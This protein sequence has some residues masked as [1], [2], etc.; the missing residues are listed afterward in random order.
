MTIQLLLQADTYYLVTGT[1]IT[2]EGALLNAL[3]RAE[4]LFNLQDYTVK[5]SWIKEKKQ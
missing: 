5:Q 4:Q 1:G 3:Q 2:Q